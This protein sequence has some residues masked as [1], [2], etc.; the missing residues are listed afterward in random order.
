MRPLKLKLSA[1]G[2]YAGTVELDFDSLG[3]RGLYL[4]TGDTGAGKTT[5]FDA[6]SF[7]LFGEASG[8]NREPSMLRSK[9]AEAAT[10]TEVDLTFLYA[11]NTYQVRRNPEYM[12]PKTRGEGYTKHAADA[13]L[14]LPDGK[15]ITKLKDV[16]TMIRDIIGLDREQFAQ[17]A[18]IAQ[19]DF[20]KLL[21]AGTRERQEIFRSIFS[22][23]CYVTLQNKL[24]DSANTVWKQWNEAGQSIRQYIEGIV[25][26]SDSAYLPLVEKARAGELPVAD[27]LLLLE[28]LLEE[29]NAA[30]AAFT[31]ELSAVETEM[32]ATIALLTQATEQE[33]NRKSLAL[34]QQQHQDTTAVL[35]QKKAIL[36]EHQLRQPEQD[37]LAHSIT[38]LELSLP[39]YD[40]LEN[41]RLLLRK[42]ENECKMLQLECERAGH[43]RN[44]QE[45]EISALRQERTALETAG[46]DK[47]KYLAQRT[48][49]LERKARLEQVLTAIRNL[50]AQ[51]SALAAA[52]SDYLCAAEK[53]A[54]LHHEYE[55]RN[56]A[57]LDEQ[58]GIL[59]VTLTPGMACP[60][61]GST[62]HP[63]PAA[64]AQDAPTE[65]AVKAARDA[66]EKARNAAE[67]LSS[68]AGQLKGSV[69]TAENAILSDLS[70]L[71]GESSIDA[72]TSKAQENLR[73]CTAAI[74]K[75]DQ[76]IQTALRNE[77][78]KATLDAMLPEKEAALTGF[79]KQI[80]G[81][82]EKI[83][84]L[85]ASCQ[86]MAQ[87][88]ASLMEKLPFESKSM[89]SGQIRMLRS[90]LNVMREAL[91]N[92][93][94]DCIACDREV[95]ALNARMEQLQ[96]TISQTPQIDAAAHMEK[97]NQ[98]SAQKTA[99][100]T[101]QKQLHTR[102]T[103]NTAS[104]ANIRSKAA[105]LEE[106]E[107]KLAWLRALSNT[108]NG[109]ISGKEKIMLETYIQTTYFDRILR[110]A[111][112][113][114]MKMTGG[115]YDLKRRRTAQNNVSQSGL[116]LDVVDH[117][118]GTE[119]S[120]KTLS[121]GESFK[122]S[123]ALALGL[124]DEV[125]M[126]TGIRVDTLF[127]DEGFGSLDPE[128]LEQAYRTL[129]GLTEGNRLVGIISH[130]SDLKEKI[131]RQIIVTKDKSGGSHARLNF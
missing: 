78:R 50:D 131:D 127:V 46:V 25:C 44:K 71:L 41:C 83:A 63:S 90:Q 45:E 123:L 88:A 58:A 79:D 113:R 2:P 128:S 103:V 10:P 12:R 33:R 75:L 76:Q 72:G 4:I 55:N 61:C 68:R 38:Q 23:N 19:G 93:Q 40:T 1:F 107:Q 87:H 49:Y 20:L 85:T 102:L 39:E 89:A 111:N 60:V 120:V 15:V 126:S 28:K 66:A 3:S 91:S 53:A 101:Q 73:E 106:L 43:Q 125:Q 115:Q 48:Q 57:F 70:V 109:T 116:E 97:R 104:L 7:A 18:M 14:T 99:V 74:T 124:S 32:D 27:I 108:A 86:E 9:Y 36:E 121:G 118:N 37:A 17:V 67:A 122:A 117:Y 59:A 30:Q 95:S 56:R 34:C 11:G 112:V 77:K 65:A 82:R 47:E 16:N 94:N 92:A 64:L 96:E 100:S 80:S 69:E 24:K 51:R 31:R 42:Q 13:Q 21:L 84:A 35:M 54:G 105:A 5:I 81:A 6:I 29:D 130:V 22:T 110:R 8:S 129:A 114:L 26:G 119:R 98:L 62:H 52:Q